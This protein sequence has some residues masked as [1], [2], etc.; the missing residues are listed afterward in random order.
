MKRATIIINLVGEAA[1]TSNT[2]IEKEI[3]KDTKIPWMKNIVGVH[4]TPK[5]L[6]Q[7]KKGEVI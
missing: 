6:K 7:Q 4:V 1:E 3:I 5:S 2:Q